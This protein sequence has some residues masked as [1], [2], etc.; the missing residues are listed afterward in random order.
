MGRKLREKGR[1]RRSYKR[2]RTAVWLLWRLLPPSTPTQPWCPAPLPR[3]PRLSVLASPPSTLSSFPYGEPTHR[4]PSSLAPPRAQPREDS[5]CTQTYSPLV[6]F[7]SC[8][9]ISPFQP[10]AHAHTLFSPPVCFSGAH[11]IPHTVN[12]LATT[13]SRSF[14]RHLTYG[15][16]RC[17]STP[18]DF[19]RFCPSCSTLFAIVSLQ[20]SSSYL[21]FLI[22]APACAND[23]ICSCVTGTFF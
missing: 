17:H 16:L 12:N 10:C 2:N 14:C 15:R 20:R 22:R 11:G 4:C 7:N 18:A 9:P 23:I 13:Y 1:E 6:L 8:L 21:G 19:Y 3:H 5:T